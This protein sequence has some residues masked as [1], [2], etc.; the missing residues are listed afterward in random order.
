[1]SETTSKWQKECMDAMFSGG[2]FEFSKNTSI[3]YSTFPGKP[4]SSKAFPEMEYK[5]YIL[6]GCSPGSTSHVYRKTGKGFIWM[7]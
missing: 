6:E 5:E 4:K 1:M 2:T 7:L 3:Y